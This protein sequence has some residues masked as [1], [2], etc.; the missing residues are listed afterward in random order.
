MS[1]NQAFPELV[2]GHLKRKI[3]QLKDEGR[4][5]DAKRLELQYLFDASEDDLVATATNRHYEA[6]IGGTLTHVER[7]YAHHCCIEINFACKAHCRYCLRSNYD[8][9]TI[10][11]DEIDEIMKNLVK[12]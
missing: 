6:D 2:S 5:V 8:K 3:Q 12:Y 11:Q 1:R 9:W 10:S 4:S 7:L